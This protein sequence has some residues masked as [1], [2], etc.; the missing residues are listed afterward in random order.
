MPIPVLCPCTAK[1]R[2]GDHLRGKQI[3]CPKCGTVYAMGPGGGVAR[4]KAPLASPGGGPAGAPTPSTN[5]AQ[6]IAASGFSSAEEDRLQTNL[7]SDETLLWAGKPGL[8]G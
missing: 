6:I 3:Q 4:G 1:L 2:V 5:P 7:E 8:K